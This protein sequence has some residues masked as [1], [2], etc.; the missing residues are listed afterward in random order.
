VDVP[1]DVTDPAIFQYLGARI[2]SVKTAYIGERKLDEPA[3]AHDLGQSLYRLCHKLVHDVKTTTDI[4]R[5]IGI[6]RDPVMREYQYAVRPRGADRQLPGPLFAPGSAF[7]SEGCTPMT[8]TFAPALR[9]VA[10]KCSARAIPVAPESP[11][12]KIMKSQS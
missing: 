11:T 3:L 9:P 12:T 1:I 2:A 10:I 6:M 8:I 5:H 7:K 4:L